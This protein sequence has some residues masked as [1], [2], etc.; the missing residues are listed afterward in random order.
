MKTLT[1]LIC[2]LV[3]CSCQKELSFDNNPEVDTVLFKQLLTST[4]KK[5]RVVEF[6]S[7]FP[8]DYDENDSFTV[9]ETNHWKYV[10][11]YLKDDIN[12]FKEDGTLE[13]FQNDEKIPGD[14]TP[15]LLRNYKVETVD[16][17]VMFDFLDHN[18]QPFR[19]FLHE[20]GADY[21][22]L[23]TQRENA[24]LFSKF[25]AVE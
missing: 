7:D 13:I 6:Y 23:Y 3:V 8:I 15:I 4:D 1:I 5:F 10:S 18:Y 20:K 17:K 16:E 14:N 2:A 12:V 21:F 9:K 22:I 24:R 11:Y 25:I 19:Y